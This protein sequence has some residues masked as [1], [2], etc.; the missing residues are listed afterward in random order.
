MFTLWK[1]RKLVQPASLNISPFVL[2][3]I[4]FMPDSLCSVGLT[5]IEGKSIKD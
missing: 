5:S 3:F 2:L 4:P 1:E